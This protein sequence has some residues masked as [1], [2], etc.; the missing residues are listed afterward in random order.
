MKACCKNVWAKVSTE[1]RGGVVS[2]NG[3]MDLIHV[4]EEEE[5]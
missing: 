1:K 3:P 2:N 5:E 4:W